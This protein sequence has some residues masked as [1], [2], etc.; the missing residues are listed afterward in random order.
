MAIDLQ[1]EEDIS[2]MKEAVQFEMKPINT[3]F[4]NNLHGDGS[5][6]WGF[7]CRQLKR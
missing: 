2:H 7:H 3:L 5:Q 4:H 6:T 1:A